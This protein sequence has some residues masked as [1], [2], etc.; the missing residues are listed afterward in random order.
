MQQQQEARTSRIPAPPEVTSDI[1]MSFDQDDIEGYET[2]LNHEPL[3]N[4]KSK[5]EKEMW[6]HFTVEYI[7]NGKKC[8]LQQGQV[9]PIWA[10]AKDDFALING[11]SVITRSAY[12]YNGRIVVKGGSAETTSHPKMKEYESSPGYPG[13]DGFIRRPGGIRI[14]PMLSSLPFIRA[15]SPDNPK[16]GVENGEL[17]KTVVYDFRASD[18]FHRIKNYKLA[19]ITTACA[20]PLCLVAFDDTKDIASAIPAAVIDV[21]DGSERLV[22]ILPVPVILSDFENSVLTQESHSNWLDALD[23]YFR[24]H[25][26]HVSKFGIMFNYVE[27]A[28]TDDM[29]EL[30]EVTNKDVPFVFRQV[31]AADKDGL[32]SIDDPQMANKLLQ[33]QHGTFTAGLT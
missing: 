23:Y 9:V 2:P 17:G 18:F 4:S 28:A 20:H 26:S 11:V 14:Q 32:A 13:S 27:S 10:G 31:M 33:F 19:E 5:P 12:V 8:A 6:S 3:R 24:T 15:I 29:G 25:L 21:R 16:Y 7:H 1:K 22:Q 30:S